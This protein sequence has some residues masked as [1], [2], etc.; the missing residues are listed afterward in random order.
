M[1]PERVYLRK[2][3]TFEFNKV[4]PPSNNNPPNMKFEYYRPNG[5]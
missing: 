5:T 1:P 4:L 2:D 3:E